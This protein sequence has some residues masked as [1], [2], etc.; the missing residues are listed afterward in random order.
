MPPSIRNGVEMLEASSFAELADASRE[1]LVACNR[2]GEVLYAD[3]RAQRIVGARRGESL[4]VLV[5]PGC[6]EKFDDFL[7]RSC[8]AHVDSCEIPFI[9][10]GKPLEASLSSVPHGLDLLVVGFVIPEA[11]AA[12]MNQVNVMVS[13]VVDLNRTLFAQRNEIAERHS[14]LTRVNVELSESHQGILALHRELQEKSDETQH[15]NVIKTR[16]IAHLSHELRTPLHSILGLTQLLKSHTDAGLL[17]EQAKQVR[18]IRASAEELLTLI[19]DVLDLGRLNAGHAQVHIDRFRLDDFVGS[20][21]GAL[22]PLLPSNTMVD[23]VIEDAPEVVELET[24][25]TKLSQIVRNLVSNALKFTECGEVR[26][27]ITVHTERMEIRVSDTGIGIAAADIAT[28]FEEYGQVE[29]HLQQ[30]TKGTGLGLPL[31]LRLAERLGGTL[32]AESTVAKGSTFTV[33]IPTIHAEARAVHEMRA[34][35]R[36]KPAGAVSVLVV[37]DDRQTLV[38]YDTYL[39]AAGFHV[40]PARSIEEAAALMHES[41]P[42]AI[43]LD[44]LLEGDSSWGFLAAL[45]NNP[46]TQDIPVLVVSVTHQEDKARA[47]GADEFWLKPVD[48]DRLVRK[49]KECLTRDVALHRIRDAL[50]KVRHGSRA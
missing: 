11:F 23:L 24:D 9:V 4:R 45:K 18:F 41:R 3:D 32:R 7:R 33:D 50:A 26:V 31:S 12:A 5:A 29:S 42:A 48:Q 25:R 28:I 13:E 49:L 38:L 36:C 2:D 30:R 44:V 6:E 39:V 37:E 17:G 27:R 46:D 35:S 43:V 14:E 16:L 21:R 8:T 34:R 19:D 15:D 10:G 20:M 40:M 1:F 47:L 22:R